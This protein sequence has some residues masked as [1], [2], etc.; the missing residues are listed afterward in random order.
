MSQIAVVI[1]I[2]KPDLSVHEAIALAHARRYLDGFDRYLVHP[3]GLAFAFDTTGFRR[4]PASPRLF[5]TV[6][7]YGRLLLSPRFW[8][9]FAVYDNLLIYQLDSLVFGGDFEPWRGYSYVGSPWLARGRGFRPRALG[10]GGFSL[11]SVKDARDVLMSRHVRLLPRTRQTWRFLAR[12]QRFRWWLRRVR[13][14]QECAA[15]DGRPVGFHLARRFEEHEEIFWSFLAPQL[16]DR[17]RLPTPSQAVAFAFGSK[18]RLAF[19][20]NGRRLPL[21]CDAWSEHDEAFWWSFVR[22]ELADGE[23]QPGL[24]VPL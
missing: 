20:A 14:A 5:R 21:G 19:E 11:R 18:P 16:L 4:L 24:S 22:A 12:P 10:D 7:S 13:A 8:A 1:P 15:R 9:R 17:Y 6:E 3:I 23:A 2:R